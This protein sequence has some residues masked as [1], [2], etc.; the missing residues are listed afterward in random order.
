MSGPPRGLIVGWIAVNAA[1]VWLLTWWS[2]ERRYRS[3]PPDLPE[4]H[5]NEVA[6]S[7]I[8]VGRSPNGRHGWPE[9]IVL[10]ENRSTHG[11]VVLGGGRRD[12]VDLTCFGRRYE[13]H[14]EKAWRDVR[15]PGHCGSGRAYFDVAPGDSARI[16]I[17]LFIALAP[18]YGGV[19]PPVTVRVTLGR[20]VVPPFEIPAD[21]RDRPRRPRWVRF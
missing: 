13:F 11:H 8:G 3:E 5:A 7:L 20:Y 2:A 6:F 14:H 19:P 1:C 16:A 21:W 12:D 10:V 18:E 17:S 4:A 9:A 15:Q